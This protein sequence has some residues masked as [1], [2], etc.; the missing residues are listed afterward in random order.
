MDVSFKAQLDSE[1]SVP[2]QSA[3]IHALQLNGG[4]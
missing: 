4:F 1:L 3:L 2:P